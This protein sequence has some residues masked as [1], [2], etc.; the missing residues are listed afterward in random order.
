[1]VKDQ[2]STLSMKKY[3]NKK[4]M[5]IDTPSNTK[6]VYLFVNDFQW[7]VP[8]NKEASVGHPKSGRVYRAIKNVDTESYRVM[9][10][11]DKNFQGVLIDKL[12]NDDR[13]AGYLSDIHEITKSNVLDFDILEEDLTEFVRWLETENKDLITAMEPFFDRQRGGSPQIITKKILPDVVVE[14]LR[15]RDPELASVIATINEL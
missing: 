3:L 10:T 14:I 12:D 11:I 2:H 7:T 8:L 1:M 13:A 4:K 15:P 5:L 9:Y 6:I